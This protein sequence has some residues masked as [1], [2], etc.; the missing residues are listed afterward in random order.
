M[1]CCRLFFSAYELQLNVT[2]MVVI[3]SE[4]ATQKLSEHRSISF[5][6][7]SHNHWCGGY[8][9]ANR[10]CRIRS[11]PSFPVHEAP[12]TTRKC[13][14]VSPYCTHSKSNFRSHRRGG[15]AS[16]S[17]WRHG[18]PW[19]EAWLGL[20]WSWRRTSK[21]ALSSFLLICTPSQSPQQ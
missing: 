12:S 3:K 2:K 9:G 16:C 20:L 5:T 18:L 10:P 7:G 8:C 13:L 19:A 17:G 1:V 6:H 21:T 15:R 14:Q 4:T 11:M